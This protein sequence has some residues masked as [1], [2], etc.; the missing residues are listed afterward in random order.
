MK[1]IGLTGGIAAGKTTVCGILSKQTQ[2]HIEIIDCDAIVHELQRP[3]SSA[4]K[5]IQKLWPSTVSEN[6]EL[7]RAKLGEI[8]FS[9]H[10]ARR[11]LAGI[12]NWRILV[13]VLQ[14]VFG[15][16]LRS[17][18]RT[19]VIIDAPLLFETNTFTKFVTH[20]V[21]VS[22]SRT[23]QLQRLI[24]RNGLTGPEA[25]RRIN[26][27][28]SLEDK[29]RRADY[30]IQN[31]RAGTEELEQLVLECA[32]WMSR[33]RRS[34]FVET[35]LLVAAIAVYGLYRVGVTLLK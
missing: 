25:E 12:M 9:D 23:L 17:S 20:A 7:N 27:Q 21:V 3:N 11:K 32:K 4:V 24:S 16:W 30:V 28:M 1:L 33:R 6:G 29:C 2:Y 31:D 5:A 10:S 15:I 14:K 35:V 34:F 8:I 18:H 26:A 19:I 13:A 22:T